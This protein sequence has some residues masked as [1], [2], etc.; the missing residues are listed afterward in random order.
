M[1]MY[2]QMIVIGTFIFFASKFDVFS[3]NE[4]KSWVNVVNFYSTDSYNQFP[5]FPQLRG[6]LI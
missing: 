4:Y 2:S 5:F 6:S 3:K 1:S